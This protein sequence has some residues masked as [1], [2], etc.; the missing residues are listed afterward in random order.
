MVVV[1]RMEWFKM[2]REFMQ[3][4]LSRSE[5][6]NDFYR[7]KNFE[8]AINRYQVTL[9]MRTGVAYRKEK[10]MFGTVRRS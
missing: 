9:G 6:G 10:I 4:E 7:E 5:K 2:N 1:V 8:E 3:R